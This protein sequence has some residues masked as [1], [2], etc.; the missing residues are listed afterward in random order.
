MLISS[1]R[2]LLD[3]FNPRH[4][5][6]VRKKNG[7]WKTLGLPTFFP[8]GTGSAAMLQECYPT[9]F[10]F[11]HKKKSFIMKTI[12][13]ITVIKLLNERSIWHALVPHLSDRRK[14]DFE[15]F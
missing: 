15:K 9:V 7:L 3:L 11:Q 2:L 6:W 12:L 14:H 8:E 13:N 10:L 4:C 1:T 5:K